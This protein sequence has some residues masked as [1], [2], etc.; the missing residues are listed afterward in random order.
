MSQTIMFISYKSGDSSSGF[1]TQSKL[2]CN[3]SEPNQPFSDRN[4]K[5]SAALEQNWDF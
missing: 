5:P 3:E 2:N 1:K 4:I